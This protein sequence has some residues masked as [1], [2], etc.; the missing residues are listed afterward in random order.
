MSASADTL[1][2]S[3]AI[4]DMLIPLVLNDLSEDDARFRARGEE[5]P[6][7]L[8]TVGHLLHSRCWVLGTLG[9]K[10]DN[11]W[12]EHFGMTPAT[13]GADYPSISETLNAWEELRVELVRVLSDATEEELA[14]TPEKGWHEGQTVR[15]Q[16]T[17]FGW[18]EGY[19]VGVIGAL[20]KELG[21]KA[22]SEKIMEA[23]QG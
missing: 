22:P 16:V 6:S 15:D 12:S 9:T 21:Y 7:I 17:F 11:P 5:G 13:D 3:F 8:W 20:R 18:H 1:I 4:T 19:H 10:R 23:R 2:G 14:T